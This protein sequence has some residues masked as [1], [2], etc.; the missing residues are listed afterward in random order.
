MRKID[1]LLFVLLLI[2]GCQT[3]K[4]ESLSSTYQNVN[5][6]VGTGAHGH[7][8]PGATVPFGL[9]QLSPDTRTLGWDASGGY[10]YTDSTI[11]GFSH[12]HLSGTGCSDLADILVTPSGNQSP[13]LFSHENEVACPG[14]YAV[15]FN[16]LD[17]KVE[18]TATTHCGIHRYNFGDKEIPQLIFDI[19][20]ALDKEPI[21][22]A[23]L[24]QVSEYEI[25]GS[26]TSDGWIKSQPIY[27]IAS[28][29]QPIEKADYTV[30]RYALDKSIPLNQQALH[31]VFK[32]KIATPLVCKVGVSLVSIENARENLNR[33]VGNKTFDAVCSLSQKR[34]NKALAAIKVEGGVLE[35]RQNFATALY[36][37]MIVPNT[38]SDV[39][40]EYSSPCG[41]VKQSNQPIYST[42]SLW[43]TFR[44]WNPLMTLLDTTLVNHF[45]GSMLNFN[46]VTGQL[47]IW[48]L[49]HRETG[50]MIGYHSAS[51]IADAYRKGIRGYDIE[52]AYAALKKS[53]FNYREDAQVLHCL[54]YIPAD[55]FHESVSSMLEYGYDDWCIAQIAK[56]LGYK[57]ETKRFEE[58][59]QYY[60]DN[61]DTDTRFFRP[62]SS[63]GTWRSNFD[64]YKSDVDFTE[65]TP[66]QYRFF[67]PHDPAGLMALYGGKD[68]FTM[69]LDSMFAAPVTIDPE[70][71]DIS[72]S[73]GQ[74]V[75]G[76]EP[77]HGLAYLYTYAGKPWETQK[78]IRRILKK[79]YHNTPEGLCGNEDCGQMSAWYIMS[80]LGCYP[81]CPGDNMYVLTTPLFERSEICLF[82]GKKLI[83]KANDP[84]N[85]PYIYNV[86]FN[87]KLLDNLFI[88]HHQLIQGG[89]LQFELGATPLK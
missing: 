27:F 67:A 17:L 7:T 54:G 61:F 68:K 19:Q 75:H 2:V 47:P 35:D 41:H 42:L 62:K 70:L 64:I 57:E 50:C 86:H 81:M 30:S 37:T 65:A 89:T 39:N 4:I 38:V 53:A 85:N 80:S 76:N 5:T 20:Y 82:N 52:K 84:I 29:N 1:S 15:N 22:N 48:P 72:G 44:T 46:E 28:F 24:K 8:Y 13:L 51:V 3:K 21:H 18:L 69:A 83:I 43:D 55:K 14:Y 60:K 9:V 32:K 10:H 34:W 33:E 88:N 6:F 73:I 77:S 78:W 49:C 56:S 31:L 45:I 26:R 71:P 23:K 79:L 11:L 36:H 16:N 87:G 58:Y 12:T 74:Y 66:W 63:T 40:G 59:A 25:E